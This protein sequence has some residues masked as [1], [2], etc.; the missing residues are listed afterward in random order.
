MIVSL[1][2][3]IRDE[4]LNVRDEMNKAAANHSMSRYSELVGREWALTWCLDRIGAN[5]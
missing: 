5:R 3:Q 2:D 4:L 1:C